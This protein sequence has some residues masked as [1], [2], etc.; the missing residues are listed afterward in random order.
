[1]TWCHHGRVGQGPVPYGWGAAQ[2]DAAI[3]EEPEHLTWFHHGRRMTA[4]FN[5]VIGVLH[6]KRAPP[7]CPPRP[8]R[9]RR[10]ACWVSPQADACRGSMHA[11]RAWGLLMGR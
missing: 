8:A 5:H 10:R 1:M 6:T 2:A 11:R 4:K 9:S 7:R 3:L